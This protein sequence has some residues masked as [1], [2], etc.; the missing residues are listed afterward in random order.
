MCRKQKSISAVKTKSSHSHC[1]RLY[2]TAKGF[3]TQQTVLK[4]SRQ[5]YCIVE[6][7]KVES[8]T[9]QQKALMHSRQ[10]QCTTESF[11]TQQEASLRS[12]KFC[13]IAEKSVLR[14]KLEKSSFCGRN[15]R[16]VPSVAETEDK[17]TLQLLPLDLDSTFV[18]KLAATKW[19]FGA[20]S[21]ERQ[22]RLPSQKRKHKK[23]PRHFWRLHQGIRIKMG[24]MRYFSL[25]NMFPSPYQS[26]TCRCS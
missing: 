9:A 12:R 15:W 19:Y 7:F 11:A 10:L 14:Q 5:L 22:A 17:P 13:C 16:K 24:R 2:Y 18:H 6:G 26:K 21:A 23:N 1:K 20:H 8:F 25:A 4:H 3:K